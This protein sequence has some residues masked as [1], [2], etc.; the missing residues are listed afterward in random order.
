MHSESQV[1]VS[2]FQYFRIC[3]P[4]LTARSE[5]VECADYIPLTNM[6]CN[7]LVLFAKLTS[8]FPNILL[9]WL[10]ESVM[11][12]AFKKIWVIPNAKQ[13]FWL[14]ND[15]IGVSLPGTSWFVTVQHFS[16]SWEQ[17]HS[18]A[19]IWFSCNTVCKKRY[20][21]GHK[22]LSLH[23][24]TYLSQLHTDFALLIVEFDLLSAS[25]LF[26]NLP[27]PPGPAAI[28]WKGLKDEPGVRKKLNSTNTLNLSI[29][30]LPNVTDVKKDTLTTYSMSTSQQVLRRLSFPHRQISK[31]RAS[32]RTVTLLCWQDVK[33]DAGFARKESS[34]VPS[35]EAGSERAQQQKG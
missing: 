23:K 31:T 10:S 28:L 9:S 12:Q 18:G 14:Q 15:S 8:V 24:Q 4:P 27:S 5:G 3:Q 33:Q 16:V 26:H 1:D 21:Y 19:C 30:P 29:S 6:L 34:G 7:Q 13:R 11:L 32:S 2:C 25:L 17:R 22:L 20:L 35:S